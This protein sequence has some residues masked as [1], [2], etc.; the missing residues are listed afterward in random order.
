LL[1]PTPGIVSGCALVVDYVLTIAISIASGCDAI[2]S[3]L[4]HAWTVF[5]L[6]AEF[7]VILALTGLNLRG[8]KESVLVL[9]PTFLAFMLSHVSLITYGI[10][11]HAGNLP[12]LIHDTTA[13][14]SQAVSAMGIWG[15]RLIALRAFSLGGATYTGVE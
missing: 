3:V 13:E 1:G 12:T 11:G 10:F 8:I 14:T 4:P 2:F 9:T 15:V 7:L 5:K 6:P